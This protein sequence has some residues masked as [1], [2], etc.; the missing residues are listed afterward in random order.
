M[1]ELLSKVKANLIMEH[2]ADDALL[3]SYISAAVSYAERLPA[4]PGGDS[5]RRTPY[6]PTTEQAVI[7]LSSHFYESRDGSTGGFFADNTGAAQQVWNTVNLLLQ[8]WD[9]RWQ[10]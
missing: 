9:R 6:R 3:K 5:I 10:V 1:D 4:H 8:G 7:M 2:T